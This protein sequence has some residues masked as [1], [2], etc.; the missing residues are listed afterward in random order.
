MP[1]DPRPQRHKA[2]RSRIYDPGSSA[3]ALVS[4]TGSLKTSAPAALVEG[5]FSGIALD[6]LIWTESIV[7]TGSNTVGLGV[8]SMETGAAAGGSAKIVSVVQGISTFGETFEFS[9]GVYAGDPLAGNIRRWGVMDTLEANGLFFEMSDSSFYVVSRRAG[10]DT[11]VN[12][13]DFNHEKEFI[14]TEKNAT[15]VIRYNDDRAIFQVN[16]LDE[17]MTLHIMVDQDFALTE[18]YLLGLYFENTN[19]INI[20]DV[21]MRVR[22]GSLSLL[23]T[24]PLNK[25]PAVSV[26]VEGISIITFFQE[27]SA[28]GITPSPNEQ[29]IVTQAYVALTFENVVLVE[30]S[31]TNYAK[32]RLKVNGVTIATKRTGPALNVSFDFTGAP[33]SL[34]PG[35]SVTVT[36]EH[37]NV[38]NID[39]EATIFGYA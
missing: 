6:P 8:V 20:T 3:E 13:A 11:K 23:G 27:D 12:V 37:F 30:V 10:V 21:E 33:Y 36:V 28:A 15:Y 2:A 31:G 39:A 9:T 24:I 5:D 35:D 4:F 32:Y 25:T 29:T 19:T 38:G 26:E 22:G 7:G 1:N 34:S 16:F 18:T 14:P 17:L